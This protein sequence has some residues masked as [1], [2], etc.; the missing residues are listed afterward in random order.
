VL[1]SLLAA[2]TAIIPVPLNPVIP[3]EQRTCAARTASGLGYTELRAGAGAKPV[4]GDVALVRYIGYLAASGETFDQ[5]AAAPLP[6][7]GVIAG[8]AEGLKLVPTGAIF[9]LCVPAAQ[10][11][12]AAAAG[13]IPANSDLVFQV[14]VLDKRTA[15]EVRAMESQAAKPAG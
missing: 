2:T 5:N 1:L 15:A 6:V 12:G 8:F 13:S 3:A 11:Y 10:G 14:E 7:D 9:R 4:T